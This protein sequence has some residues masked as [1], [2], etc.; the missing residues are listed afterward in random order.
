MRKGKTM[1]KEAA[2]DS[3]TGDLMKGKRG[4]IMGV[5][6]HNSIAWGVAHQLHAQGAEL[7]FTYQ[8]EFLERRVR[9]LAEQLG[10][11]FLLAADVTDDASM[12]AAFAAIKERWG[13]LDFIVHAIAFADR[14]ALREP[15]SKTTRAQFLQALDISAYSFVDVTRRASE[16]MPEGG[17]SITLT[18]LGGERVVPNYNIMGVAKAALE[19]ATRYLA[20]DLG[21]KNVRV[22]AISA[23][24]IRTLA[25]AGIG[26]GRAMFKFNETHS[27]MK[28]NVRL[29]DV[30]G[31]ALYLL[32]DLSPNVTGE[33]VHVDAGF[34]VVAM[35]R[36]E[37][38]DG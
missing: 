36:P 7:A 37:D 4:L 6:N 19:C 17:S 31:A 10:G 32:S 24:P 27:A 20:H 11:D 1:A 38:I 34:H 3:I 13:G 14:D 26:S 2:L 28:R 25:A 5:A 9:P 8:G 35:P 16:L 15:F 30:G 23:G 33:I 12:D 21:P 22:N 18:Y 29:E